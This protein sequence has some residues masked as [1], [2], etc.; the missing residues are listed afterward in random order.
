MKRLLKSKDEKDEEGKTREAK[1]LLPKCQVCFP[2]HWRTLKPGIGG[3]LTK[4]ENVWC[5]YLGQHHFDPDH[6]V[7]FCTWQRHHQPNGSKFFGEWSRPGVCS[8]SAGALF[9]NLRPLGK[10]SPEMLPSS[11]FIPLSDH[12]DQIKKRRKKLNKKFTKKIKKRKTTT[13]NAPSSNNL[14]H[15]PT[16]TQPL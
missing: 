1:G 14:S 4:H 7:K 11:Q 13:R 6:T 3:K 15:F 12:F 10:M 16:W 5:L 2:S 9:P 8:Y